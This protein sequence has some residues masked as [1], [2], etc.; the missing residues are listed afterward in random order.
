MLDQRRRPMGE[1]LA[2]YA[3]ADPAR[4][5]MPGHKG[6]GPALSPAFDVTEL[7]ATDNLHSPE[8]AIRQAQALAAEA[9]GAARSFFLVGGATAGLLGLLLGLFRP[10][11]TVLVDRM[12][13]Q[14]VLHGMLLA[15]LRP[16]YLMPEVAGN[17]PQPVD[18][19]TV[20][21]ALAAHPEARAVILGSPRYHGAVADIAAIAGIVHGAG[22]LLLVDEAH[23][24]HFPFSPALPPSCGALGAD[25][26]V[27]GAHKTLG[28]LTQSGLLH[29]GE[30]LLPMAERVARALTWCESS[31]PSYLLMASLDEARAQA[32]AGREG[33]T[34]CAARAEGLRAD[35]AALGGYACPAGPGWDPT[36]LVID[37]AGRDLTG[38]QAAAALEGSGVYVEMADWDALVLILTPQDDPAWDGRLLAGLAGLRGSGRPAGFPPLPELGRPAATPREAAFAPLEAAPL[39]RAAGRIAGAA[40]GPYPPG[41]PLYCPGERI[42]EAG[43]AYLAQVLALGGQVTGLADGCALTAVLPES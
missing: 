27:H 25:A 8:G 5:H 24:A 36:R 21:R 9:F 33:W 35:I 32:A 40:I 18:A 38:H 31:S 12:M 3:A 1:M 13:H 4:Y 2:A 26:W 28:A 23:G 7:S 29:L 10:G 22:R 34:A 19:G 20:A 14:S 37:V 17:R 11:E 39:E 15:D 42:T 30:R 16:V 41:V 43:A 6:R